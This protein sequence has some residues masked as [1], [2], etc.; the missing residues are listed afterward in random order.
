M[1]WITNNG[2]SPQNEL[3]EFTAYVPKTDLL[4]LELERK[5]CIL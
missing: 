5:L 4:S 1:F 2:P 3:F